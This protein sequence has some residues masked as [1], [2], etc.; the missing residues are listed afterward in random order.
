M[1]V[2]LPVEGRGA[3]VAKGAGGADRAVA[4]RA[5]EADRSYAL[6]VRRVVVHLQFD[7]D[8]ASLRN[9]ARHD[10]DD[11]FLAAHEPLAGHFCAADGARAAETAVGLFLCLRKTDRAGVGAVERVCGDAGSSGGTLGIAW[12]ARLRGRRRRIACDGG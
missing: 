6:A 11:F 9:I 2:L 7:G 4:E 5:L 12:R 1:C 3:A 10:H 8:V